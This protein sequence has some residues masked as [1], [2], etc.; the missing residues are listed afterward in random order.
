MK[1]RRNGVRKPSPTQVPKGE[2]LQARV[3]QSAKFLAP[4]FA[5]PSDRFIRDV[6]KDSRIPIKSVREVLLSALEE[7]LPFKV[8]EPALAVA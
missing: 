4:K 7:P 8:S 2:V 5:G 6:S 3:L 1:H